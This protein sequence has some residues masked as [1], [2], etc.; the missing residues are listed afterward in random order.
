MLSGCMDQSSTL[1]TEISCSIKISVNLYQ[2]GWCHNPEDGALHGHH[3]DNLKSHI[4]I[5]EAAAILVVLNDKHKICV[6]DR[7]LNDNQFIVG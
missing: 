5:H 6:S 2:T 7:S 3:C 4:Q 1:K